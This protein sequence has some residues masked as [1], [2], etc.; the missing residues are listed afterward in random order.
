[1]NK[2]RKSK[3]CWALSKGICIVG[4]PEGQERENRAEE[5]FEVIMA[6]TFPNHRSRKFREHYAE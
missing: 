6:K 1:M 5:T 2:N 3:N 4:M